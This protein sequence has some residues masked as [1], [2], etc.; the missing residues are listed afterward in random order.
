M[1]A[2]ISIIEHDTLLTE[3]QAAEVLNL[4]IRTLQAWRVKGNGPLFVR[5]GRSIRYRRHDLHSWITSKTVSSTRPNLEQ[6]EMHEL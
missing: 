5:A 6:G 3:T 4:S 1:H 2:S